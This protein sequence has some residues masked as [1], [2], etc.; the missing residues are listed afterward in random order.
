[1]MTGGLLMAATIALEVACSP[2]SQEV[3]VD[4]TVVFILFVDFLLDNIFKYAY[5]YVGKCV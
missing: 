1:M 2:Y 3:K 5:V 4:I